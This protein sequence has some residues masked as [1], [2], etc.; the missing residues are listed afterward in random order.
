ML[1]FGVWGD[2][3]YDF[4]FVNMNCECPICKQRVNDNALYCPNCGFFLKSNFFPILLDVDLKKYNEEHD[5]QLNWDFDSE[6]LKTNYVIEYRNE[7]EFYKKERNLKEYSM[8]AYK[9]LLYDYYSSFR[10][11]NFQG[12]LV[13]S[14]FNEKIE[15]YQLVLPTD[16]SFKKVYGDIILHYTVYLKQKIVMLD[17]ITSEDIFLCDDVSKYKE[18]VES[19]SHKEKDIFKINLLNSMK[20]N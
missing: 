20:G 4:P 3:M 10:E 9:K 7:I 5:I 11:G 6:D 18:V 15:K 16:K 12:V 14:D 13:F 1:G 8:L 17:N 19:K 2:N